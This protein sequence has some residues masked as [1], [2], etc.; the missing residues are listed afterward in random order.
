MKF[1]LACTRQETIVFLWVNQDRLATSIA[2]GAL[3]VRAQPWSTCERQSLLCMRGVDDNDNDFIDEKEP[4]SVSCQ[5]VGSRKI[6]RCSV[7]QC[8]VVCCSVV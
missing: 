5:D 3:C 4:T 8:V 1:L 7:L 2:Q 6:P